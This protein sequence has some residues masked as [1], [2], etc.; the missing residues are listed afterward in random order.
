[1]KSISNCDSTVRLSLTVLPAYDTVISASICQGETYSLYGF[2][3]STAGTYKHSLQRANGCDSTVKLTLTV[4]PKYDTVINASICQGETYSLYGFNENT[5]GNYTQELKSINGCDSTVI[6][7]LTVN[8][9]A[10]TNTEVTICDNGSYSFNGKELTQA[11]EYY[12]TLQTIAGCDSIVHLTL[13]ID[14]TSIITK[15]TVINAGDEINGKRYDTDGTYIDSL[16]TQNGCDSIIIWTLKVG[17]NE[18]DYSAICSVYPNPAEDNITVDFGDLALDG[19]QEL[20]IINNA[21]QVVYKS[22]INSRKF[23][24]DIKDFDSGAYYIIIN[25]TRTQKLIKK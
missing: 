12:D 18:I 9:K 21:G 14:T 4:Y 8:D 16:K 22:N 11:G 6:L 7:Y 13:Y 15:D 1:M 5:A 2:N 19:K 20:T 24:I 23:N 25:G 17:L 3:E 10:Q